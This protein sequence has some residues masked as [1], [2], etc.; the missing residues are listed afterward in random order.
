MEKKNHEFLKKL[1]ATFKTEAEEHVR[2]LSSG[3]LELEKVSAAG[4]Q[5]EIIETVFREAQSAGAER[6][7][8]EPLRAE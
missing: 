1:L 3:L 5:M 4:K 7:A 6:I 8:S 2:A